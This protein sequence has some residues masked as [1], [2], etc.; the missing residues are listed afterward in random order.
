MADP[1]P[2]LIA[3]VLANHFVLARLAGVDSPFRMD[4]L[5][6]LGCVLAVVMT[7]SAIASHLIDRY[8]LAPF[9]IVYLRLAVWVI[10]IAGTAKLADAALRARDPARHHSLRTYLPLMTTNSALLFMLAATVRTQSLLATALESLGAAASCT[11]AIA[12]FDALRARLD[13]S[14]I[15][16]PFR[17]T[18]ITLICIGLL[19]LGFAGFRG[20]GG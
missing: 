9:G 3:A 8:A 6:A 10:V 16:A 18:P 7:V 12:M 4:A 19:S 11:L 13:E 17:G 5:P 2:L 14:C 1:F 15:P 20:I